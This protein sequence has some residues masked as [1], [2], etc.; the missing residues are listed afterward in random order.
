MKNTRLRRG[1]FALTLAVL[2]AVSCVH[3]L[4]AQGPAAPVATVGPANPTTFGPT[5]VIG[6]HRVTLG[7]LRGLPAYMFEDGVEITPY[8]LRGS[9]CPC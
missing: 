4:R 3:A 2:A 1:A 7:A 5:F 6:A 9:T 8:T